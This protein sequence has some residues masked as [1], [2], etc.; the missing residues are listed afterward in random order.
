MSTFSE[1][2]RCNNNEDGY[3]IL[4]C[5]SCGCVHCKK[6]NQDDGSCPQCGSREINKVGQ[7]DSDSGSDEESTGSEYTECPRCGKNDDG[8]SIW[9]C[10]SC[11]CVHC[12]DCDPDSGRCP[13]CGG[14]RVKNIGHI[15]N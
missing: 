10:L 14:N 3:R 11:K 5:G 4:S 8:H 12:K 6:C 2:P 7:I 15:D 13:E 9:L 1:C